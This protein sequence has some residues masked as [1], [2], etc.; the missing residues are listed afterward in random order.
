VQSREQAVHCFNGLG[1]ADSGLQQKWLMLATQCHH[2]L[3]MLIDTAWYN[4]LWW[5]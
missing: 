2:H 3:G 1:L 5:V 4:H